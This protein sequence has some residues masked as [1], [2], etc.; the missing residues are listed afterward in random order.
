M[1]LFIAMCFFALSMSI[2][3]G[4]VNFITLSSGVNFGLKKTMPF[5]S[6]AVIGFTLVLLLVGFGVGALL[7]KSPVFLTTLC[8]IGS[9]FIGYMGYGLMKSDSELTMNQDEK[10]PS[11]FQGFL[12]QWLNP[13]AWIASLA[14]ISAFNLANQTQLMLYF[15][16][17]YFVICYFCV[18]AWAYVGDKASYYIKD[19]KRVKN[20]NR[21]MGALLIIIAIYLLQLQLMEIM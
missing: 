19:S 17:L 2:S 3:P 18:A 14:G 6:G 10:L 13:K 9:S 4:P 5:V 12:L 20:F 11:F 7:A 16:T 8:F 21:I 1:S 15:V